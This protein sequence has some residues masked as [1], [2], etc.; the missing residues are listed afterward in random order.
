[1]RTEKF[2]NWLLGQRQLKRHVV[3]SRIS[4]CNRVEQFYSDLDGHFLKDG[5]LSLIE[6]FV[7]STED[8]RNRKPTKHTIPI[9]GD[10][11]TGSATLKAAVKL[12]MEFCSFERE[13]SQVI[14]PQSS[15]NAPA[16]TR[17]SVNR[18][19]GFNRKIKDGT[20]NISYKNLFGDY[21]IGAT[22]Y[23]VNDPYVR[24]P[25]QLRNFIEFCKLIGETKDKEQYVRIHLVTKKNEEFIESTRK[26]FEEMILSL[27]NQE[28]ELTY[29]FSDS[30]H[31]R[32]IEMNNGW[33]IILGRGL[34]IWHKSN[35]RFDI[36]EYDQE[37]RICKEFEMTAIKC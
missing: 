20:T 32:S 9:D 2:E 3:Q 19:D 25:Y 16:A 1:M 5:G 36:A 34:D 31:D 35:G 37:K 8:Q 18:K 23:I 14:K 11:R 15:S 30:L 13:N 7:Y 22:E 26:S 4:N 10:K 27:K 17:L 29:E 33:R 21:V 6:L 24:L 28:I 12:Y